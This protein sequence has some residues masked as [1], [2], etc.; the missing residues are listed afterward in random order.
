MSEGWYWYERTGGI[1]LRK[2]AADGKPLDEFIHKDEIKEGM[3]VAA[4]S[5]VGWYKA[6]IEKGKYGEFYAMTEGGLLFDLDLG[7]DG[8]WGTTC[9]INTKAV[10]VGKKDEN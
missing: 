3:E 2:I 4:A 1:P 8:I 7:D 6:K 10:Q 9:S 5:V